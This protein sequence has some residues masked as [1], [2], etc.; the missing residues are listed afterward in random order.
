MAPRRIVYS[1]ELSVVIFYTIKVVYKL[2]NEVFTP[3]TE[4][5]NPI[6]GSKRIIGFTSYI[7]ISNFVTKNRNANT[8]AFS[9]NELNTSLKQL[10]RL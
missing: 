4:K 7:I 1:S 9:P 6:D 5:Y 3:M 8:E 10:F 2:L